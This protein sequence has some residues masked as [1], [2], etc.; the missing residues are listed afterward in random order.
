MSN[1]PE[2]T[3]LPKLLDPRKFAQK[4]IEL[5]GCV[6]LREMP[7]VAELTLNQ[8][9]DVDV[10]LHFSIDDQRFK[11]ITGTV[12]AELQLPCQRCLEPTPVNLESK[13]NL[14][15][16]WDEDEAKNFPKRLDPLIHGEGQTDIYAV[17]ED[18]ILLNLPMV[19]YH[20][21]DCIGKTSFGDEEVSSDL[22]S[23][24]NPFQILEQL[25]GSPKS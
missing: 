17:I 15:V 5:K 1:T 16:A 18:E 14:A 4:G 21:H 23:E 20:D 10:E 22:E 8:D 3:R 11:L 24:K 2:K 19:A 13:V 9:E 12:S 7:R 6:P 25:K